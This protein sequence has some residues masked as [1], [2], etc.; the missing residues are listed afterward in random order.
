[1]G[2]QGYNWICLYS[3]QKKVNEIY[4]NTIYPLSQTDQNEI[5]TF[6]N[7]GKVGSSFDS[8]VLDSGVIFISDDITKES[9]VVELKDNSLSQSALK[10]IAVSLF[11]LPQKN[12]Q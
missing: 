2:R 9:P 7:S 12:I 11:A 1:M 10:N 3:N 6:K 8:G 4:C 5:N